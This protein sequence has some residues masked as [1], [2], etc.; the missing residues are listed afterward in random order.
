MTGQKRRGKVQMSDKTKAASSGTSQCSGS[1]FNF[2]KLFEVIETPKAPLADPDCCMCE[3]RGF[4]QVLDVGEY[5]EQQTT[6]QCACK[7]KQNR[8]ID[9]K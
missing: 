3:G 9:G 1:V 4:Y 5:D 7:R 8:V 2:D 6:V